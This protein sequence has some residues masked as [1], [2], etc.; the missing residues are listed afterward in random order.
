MATDSCPACGR[1]FMEFSAKGRGKRWCWRCGL[2]LGKH[3]KWTH[4]GDGR[5]EHRDCHNPTGKKLP[6]S[7]DFSF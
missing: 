4:S 7:G 3:D 2:K 1:P 6:K 5:M